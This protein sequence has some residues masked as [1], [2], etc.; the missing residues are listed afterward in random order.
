VVRQL[1]YILLGPQR[2]VKGIKYRRKIKIEN[3]KKGK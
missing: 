2:L 1:P 3:K